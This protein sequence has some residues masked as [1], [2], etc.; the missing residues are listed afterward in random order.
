MADIVDSRY[1]IIDQAMRKLGYEKSALLEVLHIA[2]E[3]F[4]YL[5]RDALKF[6]AKRL[7]APYSKVYGVATFYHRFTLK[8]QGKHT[9]VVCLGTACY[10]KGA[11]EILAALETRFAIKVT[12]TTNDNLLS[13]LSARC[14]G[15]CS[16]APVMICDNKTYGKLTIDETLEKIEEILS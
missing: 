3:T 1:K 7:K 14:V 4:G 13:L 16:I 5:D 10:I 2:Q 6:I 11:K 12:Q 15:S 8:P 9:L